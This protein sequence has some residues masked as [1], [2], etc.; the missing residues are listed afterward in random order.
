MVLILP[1]GGCYA[2]EGRVAYFHLVCSRRHPQRVG[3]RACAVEYVPH[4]L[5]RCCIG[6]LLGLIHQIPRGVTDPVGAWVLDF[7]D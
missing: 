5:L 6:W 1:L 3:T 4:I 2:L 7:I